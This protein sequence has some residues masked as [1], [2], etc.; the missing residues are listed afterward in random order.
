MLHPGMADGQLPATPMAFFPCCVGTAVISE[1]RYDPATGDTVAEV[2]PYLAGDQSLPEQLSTYDTFGRVVV[3]KRPDGT[4]LNYAYG[5]GERSVTD[6]LGRK[7][8]VTF[9]TLSED[10]QMAG[11]YRGGSRRDAYGRIT[12]RLYDDGSATNL[13]YDG[14]SPFEQMKEPDRLLLRGISTYPG[15]S[16]FRNHL[17]FKGPRKHCAA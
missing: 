14:Y 17:S 5:L 2:G 10:V 3:V 9:D 8:S 6:P 13:S 1:I 4:R 7:T 12:A 11:L 15:C 16:D